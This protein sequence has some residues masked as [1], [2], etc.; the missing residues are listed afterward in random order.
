M[1]ER[2]TISDDIDIEFINKLPEQFSNP[3]NEPLLVIVDDFMDE[4]M[5]SVAVSKLYVHCDNKQ[6]HH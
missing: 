6:S 2:S 5:N 1:P 3:S 4:A